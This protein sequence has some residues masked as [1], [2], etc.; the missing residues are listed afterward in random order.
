VAR[1]FVVELLDALAEIGL[2]HLD[3]DPWRRV[4]SYFIEAARTF[5]LRRSF[6]AVAV[7]QS[8]IPK[9]VPPFGKNSL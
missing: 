6:F 9:N 2:E 3:A 5:S 8:T 1:I 7:A 4:G